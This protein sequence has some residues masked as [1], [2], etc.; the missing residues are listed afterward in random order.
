[1]KEAD[2][3]CGCQYDHLGGPVVLLPPL[4]MSSISDIPGLLFCGFHASEG[5]QMKEADDHCG[6]QY[7]HLGVPVEHGGSKRTTYVSAALW[8]PCV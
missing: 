3:H 4:F 8:L 5:L 6:R 1:M 7:D 2:D